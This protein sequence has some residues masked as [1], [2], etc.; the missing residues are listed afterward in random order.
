MSDRKLIYLTWAILAGW[1]IYSQY[2]LPHYMEHQAIA[3]A[4]QALQQG[5]KSQTNAN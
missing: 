4:I 1:F 2:L 5:G 3:R